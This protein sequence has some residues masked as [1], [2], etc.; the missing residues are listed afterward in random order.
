MTRRESAVLE[1][2]AALREELASAAQSAPDR[3]LDIP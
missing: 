2:A 1:L 3:L